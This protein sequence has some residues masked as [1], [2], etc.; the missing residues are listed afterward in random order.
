MASLHLQT[1]TIRQLH[2]TLSMAANQVAVGAFRRAVN[3]TFLDTQPLYGVYCH[4]PK[5][6]LVLHTGFKYS[7]VYTL[8]RQRLVGYDNHEHKGDHRHFR[9]TTTPYIFTT[10]DRLIEDFRRDVTAV[11]KETG[12]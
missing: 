12:R 7:L 3:D 2:S 10:V 1:L 6:K 5:A 4:M 9:A 8:K 11:K